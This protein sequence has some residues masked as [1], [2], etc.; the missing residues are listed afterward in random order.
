[1]Q[2]ES[3]S[4]RYAAQN[5]VH[6]D[7]PAL[8][9]KM[10]WQHLWTPSFKGM[11]AAVVVHTTLLFKE[12]TAM[13]EMTHGLVF[14]VHIILNLFLAK[15]RK[16]IKSSDAKPTSHSLTSAYTY[17]LKQLSREESKIHPSMFFPECSGNVKCNLNMLQMFCLQ[18]IL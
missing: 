5:T 11:T 12:F 4:N 10:T 14:L 2:L 18:I 13:W 7:H 17:S 15:E 3:V 1:M 9:M 6:C 16:F 8:G